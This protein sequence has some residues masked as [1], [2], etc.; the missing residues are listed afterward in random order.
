MQSGAKAASQAKEK[1]ADRTTMYKLA[2]T[3]LFLLLLHVSTFAQRQPTFSGA[4]CYSINDILEVIERAAKPYSASFK[5][6][7][8]AK[9]ASGKCLFNLT[10]G[11]QDPRF[12]IEDANVAERAYK[13]EG[14][15]FQAIIVRGRLGS[16]KSGRVAYSFLQFSN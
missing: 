8:D 14:K 1:C 10:E 5:A 4:V 6:F 13:M 15:T 12:H 2:L 7:W 11:G 3:T 16:E 9:K